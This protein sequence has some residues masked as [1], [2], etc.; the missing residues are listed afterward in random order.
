M[1]HTKAKVQSQLFLTFLHGIDTRL[2]V[3]LFRGLGFRV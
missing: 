2:R 1:D 3:L